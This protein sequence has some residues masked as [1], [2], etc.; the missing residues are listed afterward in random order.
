MGEDHFRT[1]CYKLLYWGS[2]FNSYH[3]KCYKLYFEGSKLET[4]LA[5]ACPQTPYKEIVSLGY[6]Q[7]YIHLTRKTK[8]GE[9]Y[10]KRRNWMK[11]TAVQIRKQ[12]VQKCLHCKTTELPSTSNCRTTS[13]LYIAL[14]FNSTK[15][16]HQHLWWIFFNHTSS[17]THLILHRQKHLN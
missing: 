5:G 11:K 2:R 3:P 4:F 13:E 6:W 12:N 14:W 9:K 8:P 1:K 15:I 7:I 16:K 10:A 17:G